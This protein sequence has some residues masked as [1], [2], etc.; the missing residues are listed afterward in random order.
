ML[1]TPKEILAYILEQ[2]EE[3]TIDP[4]PHNGNKTINIGFTCHRLP[5]MVAAR[6]TYQ[7][8]IVYG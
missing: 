6:P 2:A 4:S 3:Q 1:S 8:I 7:S 5:Q